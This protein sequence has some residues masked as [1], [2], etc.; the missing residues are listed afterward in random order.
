M[1]TGSSRL[2]FQ[3]IHLIAQQCLTVP[4]KR[5]DDA[6]AHGGF[7]RR[8]GNDENREHVP[9]RRVTTPITPIV[10]NPRLRNK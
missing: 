5:D 3:Q 2:P 1:H 4:E 8:V 10:N 7:R 6:Q 9:F